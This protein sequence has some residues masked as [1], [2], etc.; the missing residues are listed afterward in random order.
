MSSLLSMF[1]VQEK[2]PAVDDLVREITNVI[3]AVEIEQDYSPKGLG[4][5]YKI[6]GEISYAVREGDNIYA[7]AATLRR[8][9]VW[10]KP[11]QIIEWNNLT[12]PH[13]YLKPDTALTLYDLV[14]EPQLVVASWYGPGFHGKLMANAKIFDQNDI[15]AAHMYLPLGMKVRVTNVE[16]G[17]SIEVPITDRGNFEKYERGIDLSKQAAKVLG[18]HNSG[19]AKVLI[20]PLPSL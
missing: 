16:N 18:Y 12:P 2:T 3:S 13:Y 15:V 11:K 5:H 8:A 9:G 1:S 14:W 4:E 6:K 10:V 7:V 20:E 19:T 17:I